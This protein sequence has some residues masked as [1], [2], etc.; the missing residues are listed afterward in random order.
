MGQTYY[1]SGASLGGDERIKMKEKMVT[2]KT[3]LLGILKIEF[4]LL[5]EA[6]PRIFIAASEN[7]ERLLL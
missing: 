7:K 6:F 2:I 3:D 1:S 5:E 4:I